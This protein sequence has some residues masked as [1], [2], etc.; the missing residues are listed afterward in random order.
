ME[1]EKKVIDMK[2]PPRFFIGAPRGRS[3][4][5]TVSIAIGR[6][7][8]K[9]GLAVQPFKK[10]PDYIDP[11][12]LALACG[13]SCSNL[14][15]FLMREEVLM[16]SF[17]RRSLDAD[18]VFVEGSMGLFDSPEPDGRGSVAWLSRMLQA[19][20]ILVVNAERMT[21]S[22]AALVSGF[23]HFEPGTN[24]SGVILNHV[25][26]SRHEQKLLDAVKHY[27]GIPV[28]GVVPRDPGLT[29]TERHLGL[30]PSVEDDEAEAV[31]Q[32]I[33]DKV[34]SYLNLNAIVAIARQ[35]PEV[36]IADTLHTFKQGPAGRIGVIMDRAF[37]FYYP[38]NVEALREAGADIVPIDAI[39]DRRLPDIDGLY[40]GGGFPE[41]YL[42][43]LEANHGIRADIAA[44][45]EDG[46]PT[47]A[48]C[49]GLMYLCRA[50]RWQGKRYEM[51]G[52]IPAEVEFSRRPEGHGYAEMKVRAKNPWFTPGCVLRGHE[53]HHSKLIPGETLAAAC[54]V[55]RGHGI[56]GRGDGFFY[57]NLFAS[58]MHIHALG[59]PQWV[60][61]F[62][63]LASQHRGAGA[64]SQVEYRANRAGSSLG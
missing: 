23:Q 62:V 49:A 59:V 8:T 3:G 35:A 60:H 27:C 2:L 56:D 44:R 53:F 40:I 47:Y 18:L 51:V 63:S 31:V 42:S 4:K 46:L 36:S 29:I 21:R 1:L 38:E 37:S 13:R 20:V 61:S 22:I 26:G 10:G 30:T 12:W 6:A 24:V 32:T 14:D 15:S 25:S 28:L 7:L 43:E 64:A 52:V 45:I 48:E 39:S 41:L 34:G 11:S 16:A 57:R 58:Y 5:T 9:R 54:K 55:N 33:C 17:A 50:I 19:P